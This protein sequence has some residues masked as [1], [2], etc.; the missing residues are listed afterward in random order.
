MGAWGIR[1][2]VLSSCGAAVARRAVWEGLCVSSFIAFQGCGVPASLVCY[3]VSEIG[4]LLGDVQTVLMPPGFCE[5]RDLSV[6]LCIF[7]TCLAFWPRLLQLLRLA[8]ACMS[9]CP[10]GI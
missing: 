4:T 3:I 7:H 6:V 2:P 5:R 9:I 1:P 10:D 8:L